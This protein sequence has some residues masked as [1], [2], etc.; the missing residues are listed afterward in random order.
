MVDD[1]NDDDIPIQKEAKV[2]IPPI[3]LLKCKA[4][5]I[6]RIC[7]ANQIKNYLVIKISIG[8]KIFC[9][10]KNDFDTLIA[11][12]E[13]KIE[14]FTYANKS[15]R[16]NKALLQG[17]DLMEGETLKNKLIELGL[18]CTDEDQPNEVILYVVYFKPKSTSLNELKKNFTSI[19]H[20]RVRWDFQK[21]RN[22]KVTQCFNCQMFGHVSSRCR[23][24]SF[25]A[26]WAS[27]STS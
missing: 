20:T 26:L 3:T 12:I 8:H 11:Q 27:Y 24:R 6:H 18:Q 4:E 5:E 10:N 19:D 9:E 14:Y 25:F 22:N 16:P 7:R 23:V 21:A 2:Q 17:L 15:K 1:E 13:N